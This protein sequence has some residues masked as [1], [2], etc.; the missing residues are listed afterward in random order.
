MEL[1]HGSV[2]RCR[3]CHGKGLLLLLAPAWAVQGRRGGARC[4][5]V[6]GQGSAHIVTEQLRCLNARG[7]EWP[8]GP[9]A[10]R[11]EAAGGLGV[12]LQASHSLLVRQHQ[13]PQL[14]RLL[15][16]LRR[17]LRR[18]LTRPAPLQLQPL[19]AVGRHPPGRRTCEDGSLHH[20]G[21]QAKARG[22]GEMHLGGKF[23]GRFWRWA[24]SHTPCVRLGQEE[25]EDAAF[26]RRT[27]TSC[28]HF[29]RCVHARNRMQG[30]PHPLLTPVLLGHQVL[31]AVSR[32][33]LQG[34]GMYGVSRQLCM[35]VV[36]H[37]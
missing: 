28:V 33:G 2:G 29:P 26:S 4:G 25:N 6:G 17:H 19:L 10:W 22:G 14:L 13:P 18:A 36:F 32:G 23:R 24:A 34:K 21:G 9:L 16:L 3:T 15:R 5:C 7:E 37:S 12:Y 30:Q 1:K 8:R 31:L 27:R 11:L 20:G 35:E